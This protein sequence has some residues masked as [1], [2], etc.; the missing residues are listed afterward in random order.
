MPLWKVSNRCRFHRPALQ[1]G[2]RLVWMCLKN[3][4]NRCQHQDMVLNLFIAYN[5]WLL[6][7]RNLSNEIIESTRCLSVIRRTREKEFSV[8]WILTHSRHIPT[9]EKIWWV[10]PA[11]LQLNPLCRGWGVG[12]GQNPWCV[13]T[14]KKYKFEICVC[15]SCESITHLHHGHEREFQKHSHHHEKGDAFLTVNFISPVVL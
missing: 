5:F 14:G 13:F 10:A 15:V 6:L 2:P 11:P 4:S 12:H 8:A 9:V 3:V 1:L 7:V